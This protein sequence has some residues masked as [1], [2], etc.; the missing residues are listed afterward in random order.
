VADDEAGAAVSLFAPSGRRQ[1]VQ[2]RRPRLQSVALGPAEP[3]PAAGR[4]CRR[5]LLRQASRKTIFTQTTHPGEP[6]IM[7][8]LASSRQRRPHELI[9]IDADGRSSHGLR[10]PASILP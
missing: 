5:R 4:P 1:I 7:P 10:R 6:V 2:A 8:S 3:R 9:T